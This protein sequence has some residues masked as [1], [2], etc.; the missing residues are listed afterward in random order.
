VPHSS[1]YW[2]DQFLCFSRHRPY[3]R[4]HGQ[5][6]FDCPAET[7]SRPTTCSVESSPAARG[8]DQSRHKFDHEGGSAHT[9]NP[10]RIDLRWLVAYGLG[11]RAYSP[12]HKELHRR[13]PSR[14]DGPDRSQGQLSPIPTLVRDAL[15]GT[16][17]HLCGPDGPED[18]STTM[19]C[20][21][22][23]KRP[24]IGRKSLDARSRRTDTCGRPLRSET[25]MNPA[26]D[27]PTPSTISSRSR[28]DLAIA[29]VW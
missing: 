25:I 15:S 20:V 26:R 2:L 24:G 18:V 16:A 29:S 1:E 8:R 13:S 11:R 5:L 28:A 10:Y 7:R 17:L 19:T 21:H 6:E 12:V 9:V 4:R 23:T 14:S 27:R 22:V 3:G